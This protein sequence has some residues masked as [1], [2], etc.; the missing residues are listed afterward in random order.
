MKI[1]INTSDLLL[2]GWWGVKAWFSGGFGL[3]FL[4]SVRQIY[5][6]NLG[7]ADDVNLFFY[8]RGR[9]KEAERAYIINWHLTLIYII[10]IQFEYAVVLI[11]S[12]WTH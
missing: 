12:L 1:E 11:D 6:K 10:I 3:V 2:L 4:E 8:E 7:L 9:K 5:P